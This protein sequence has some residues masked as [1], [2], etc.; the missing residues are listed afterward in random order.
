MFQQFSF[1]FP[2][3]QTLQTVIHTY[4]ECLLHMIKTVRPFNVVIYNLSHIISTSE[5]NHRLKC[6][7]LIIFMKYLQHHDVIQPASVPVFFHR[8]YISIALKSAR[9]TS[10][11]LLRRCTSHG[12]CVCEGMG[13]SLSKRVM[14]CRCYYSNLF[15]LNWQCVNCVVRFGAEAKSHTFMCYASFSLMFSNDKQGIYIDISNSPGM[16]VNV[17]AGWLTDRSIRNKG[18]YSCNEFLI[19]AYVCVSLNSRAHRWFRLLKC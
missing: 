18:Q 5:R 9:W 10:L 16:P 1:L 6:V 8:L 15:E 3:T 19:A 17:S 4:F 2:I 12:S 7:L 14:S 13:E 11:W